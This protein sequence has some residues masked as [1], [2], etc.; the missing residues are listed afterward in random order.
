MVHGDQGQGPR[1]LEICKSLQV[2]ANLGGIKGSWR[3][4][5]AWYS[6]RL[7]EAIGEYMT[8]VEIEAHD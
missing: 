1:T 7:G 2:G 3:A 8:S 5:D 6:R 4:V